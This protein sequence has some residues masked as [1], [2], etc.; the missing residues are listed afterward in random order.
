VGFLEVMDGLTPCLTGTSFGRV[1]CRF[2]LSDELREGKGIVRG[3]LL[4][5]FGGGGAVMPIWGICC[6]AEVM[7]VG[8]SEFSWV[9]HQGMGPCV[10]KVP[11][12]R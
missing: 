5:E 6:A 11:R 3:S 9:S 7:G 2:G 12:F 10:K 8:V 1:T 4:L